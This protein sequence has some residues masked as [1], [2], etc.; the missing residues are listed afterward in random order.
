M[1]KTLL[2]ILVWGLTVMGVAAHAGDWSSQEMKQYYEAQVAWEIDHC[3]QKCHLMDSRSPTLRAKARQEAGK[4]QYLRTYKAQLVNDMLAA[5][6]GPSHYKVQ[7]FLNERYHDHGYAY[8]D[9][10]YCE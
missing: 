7:Q 1:R 9:L 2:F 3:L 6:I 5:E 8:L 10:N 4:A